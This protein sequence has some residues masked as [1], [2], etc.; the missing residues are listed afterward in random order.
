VPGAGHDCP[1]RG[2]LFDGGARRSDNLL[3]PALVPP[4]NRLISAASMSSAELLITGGNPAWSTVA[5]SY[6]AKWVA[7]MGA[8]CGQI[9]HL[10]ETHA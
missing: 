2:S 6:C 8:A 1:T 10:G 5:I 3:K 7:P 9:V 4:G